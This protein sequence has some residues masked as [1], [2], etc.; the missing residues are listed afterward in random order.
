[1]KTFLVTVKKRHIFFFF[2]IDIEFESI[3]LHDRP[4]FSDTIYLGLLDKILLIKPSVDLSQIEC[5]YLKAFLI[6][7]SELP[8]KK[9]KK[10][11]ESSDMLG[12]FADSFIKW[13]S[14]SSEKIANPFLP[15]CYS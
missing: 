4:S 6:L 14:V 7:I 12:L 9:S 13:I 10:V 2:Q 15:L 11:Y 1:V 5:R 3:N 8:S